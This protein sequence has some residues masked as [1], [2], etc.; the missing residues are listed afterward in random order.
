MLRRFCCKQKEELVDMSSETFESKA[1]KAG[2]SRFEGGGR[3]PKMK[4]E[5]QAEA[6]N[7]NIDDLCPETSGRLWRLSSGQ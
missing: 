7:L 5:L 1:S 6:S 4:V 2:L 3:W